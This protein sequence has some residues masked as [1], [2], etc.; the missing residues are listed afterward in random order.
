MNKKIISFAGITKNT[1]DT[2]SGDGECQDLLN[3][4][5]KDGALRPI[6][7]PLLKEK[8]GGSY[9]MVFRHVGANY[10]NY[11]CVRN[12]EI[13]AYISSNDDIRE[14]TT[15]LRSDSSIPIHDIRIIGNTLSVITQTGIEYYLFKDQIYKYLGRK[16]PFPVIQ[17][18]LYS[19]ETKTE[20][21]WCDIDPAIRTEANMTYTFDSINRTKVTTAL[22]GAINRMTAEANQ[23][24]YFVFPILVRY[25]LRLFDGNYILHSSPIVL[26]TEQKTP[27]NISVTKAQDSNG[28]DKHL[29]DFYYDA[30]VHKHQLNFHADFKNIE[31]WEDIITSIDVFVSKQIRTV[32]LNSDIASFKT[33]NDRKNVTILLN[34]YGDEKIKENILS[35]SIFYKIHSFSLKDSETGYIQKEGMLD[36]LELKE[37]LP[38]DPFSHNDITGASYVYNSRLHI[39]AVKSKLAAMLPVWIFANTNLRLFDTDASVI[40]KTTGTTEV[41]L[42]TDSGEK[43]VSGELALPSFRGF[44]PM[45][46]YPDSRAKKII[47]HI[48]VS[49]KDYHKVFD[50]KP[51]PY[52]NISYY[53]DTLGPLGIDQFREGKVD[54]SKNN[55]IEYTPNKLKVSEVNNPFYFPIKNTYTPS[56]GEI[57]AMCSNTADIST[58]QFGQYP[59][60]VFCDDGIYSMFVGDGNIVYSRS[61]PLARDVCINKNVLPIDNAV[62]FIT[63]QGVM[64]ISG[65]QIQKIST[66]LEG[67]VPDPVP[68]IAK[69]LMLGGTSTFP[70]NILSYMS[71]Y[72]L[73]FNYIQREI[74][75]SNPNE[76][77]SYVYSMANGTWYRLS[78]CITGY[79]R[80]SYPD[81]LA[82]INGNIYDMEN[83]EGCSDIAIISR[84]LKIE[85]LT[86]KRIFQGSLRG[87]FSTQKLGFY[88]LGSND[89]FSYDLVSKKETISETRDL[90]AQMNRSRSYKYFV[91]CVS[92][93]LHSNSAINF[94]EILVETS[95]A[96]RLR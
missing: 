52:L 40:Q 43:I 3:I 92:G 1:D 67:E 32:D 2:I 41:H 35:A 55:D 68:I 71:T 94:A 37:T 28:D 7:P 34:E 88:I 57:I 31:E 96:N 46:S 38:D 19:K 69:I 54:T 93:Q 58:G 33:G 76:P 22:T 84:P 89:C 26:L 6:P 44:T 81:C 11:I 86:H 56:N 65:S 83:H 48:N 62:I 85:T 39:G 13:D 30:I 14:T 64:A 36:N 24:G 95:F 16:P 9:E 61:A 20:N 82:L 4:R 42:S 23:E 87:Y 80:N 53:I 12:G 91:I 77:Y 72:S 70:D 59:L 27:A 49:G 29:T 78:G 63:A 10:D 15:L 74:L 73:G 47:W 21:L 90:I 60:Y 5:I 79:V 18:K 50:M 17:F 75:I 25:A 66:P 45:I 8:L 51:H